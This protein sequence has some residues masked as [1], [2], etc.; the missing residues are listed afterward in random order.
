MNAQSLTGNG[1]YQNG[2]GFANIT[3]PPATDQ[4]EIFEIRILDSEAEQ[5]GPGLDCRAVYRYELR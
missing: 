2:G 4:D 3:F 5:I 1:D